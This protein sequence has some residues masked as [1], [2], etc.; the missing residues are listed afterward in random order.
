MQSPTKKHFENII[1]LFD[2]RF[3]SRI[4]SQVAD[5]TSVNKNHAKILTISHIGCSNHKLNLDVKD[6][7]HSDQE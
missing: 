6:M 4:L 2:I 3:R 7:I 1:M 5:N